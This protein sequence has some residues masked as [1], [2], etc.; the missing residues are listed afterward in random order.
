MKKRRAKKLCCKSGVATKLSS[1]SDDQCVTVP[2]S[3]MSKAVNVS[4]QGQSLV[5][6]V[7]FL[8]PHD[9]NK[10]ISTGRTGTPFGQMQF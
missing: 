5:V 3:T 2:D 10:F 4:N 6:R 1:E 9:K 8:S 7:S